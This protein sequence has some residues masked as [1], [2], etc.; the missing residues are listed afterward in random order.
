MPELSYVGV[1]IGYRYGV[2]R[3]AMSTGGWVGMSKSRSD[4]DL[5]YVV[6]KLPYQEW[7]MQRN[8]RERE[9]RKKRKIKAK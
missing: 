7:R 3:Q 4:G 1:V 2:S 8:E 9:R 5:T 6:R